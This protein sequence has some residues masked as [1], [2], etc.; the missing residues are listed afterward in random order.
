M[1]ILRTATKAQHS[2][3]NYSIGIY[4]TYNIMLVSGDFIVAYIIWSSQ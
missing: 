2:Q 4:L 3:I 1:K